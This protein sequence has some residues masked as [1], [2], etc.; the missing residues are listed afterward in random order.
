MSR[1]LILGLFIAAVA[2]AGFAQSTYYLNCGSGRDAA[3]GL[4]PESAWD[5]IERAN[6]VLFQPGDRLVLRRGSTCDGMLAPK[7]SGEADAPIV[8]SAYGEGALPVIR[9]GSHTAGLELSNQEYWEIEDLEIM[10]GSPY[11]LHITTGNASIRHFRLRNLV[12]HHVIGEPKMKESGLLVVSPAQDAAGTISDVLI[13]GVTAYDTTQWAGILVTGAAF[14][15]KNHKYGEQIEIRNSVVHDI[16]GDG[17]LLMSVRKGQ[18]EHNVAWN[19]GMQETET[20][21][22]PNAIWEWMCV[23]CRVA[24][25]EGFFSDSPG[26]DGGIF[27]IDFGDIDNVVEHNFGHDSQ[28]YCA[29]VFGAEGRGGNSVNSILRENTC[30][31]NA[32]SPRLARRQGAIFVDTWH[33][34]K[35]DGVLIEGNTILWEPP[36]AAPA[37]HAAAEFTGSR[38]NRIED[39]RILLASGDAIQVS[40]AFTVGANQVCAATS[41][42]AA[43]SLCRCWS[44]WTASLHALAAPKAD[45]IHLADGAGSGWRLVAAF[46]ATPAGS[47][48][49]ALVVLLESMRYQFSPLGL[50]TLI[51]PSGNPSE[52][53]MDRL[54]TDWHL[55]PSILVVPNVA[56]ASSAGQE[57]PPAILLMNPD[58]VVTAKWRAP[59]DPAALWLELEAHLGVPIGMQPSPVCQK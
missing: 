13:D 39:N 14:N 31:H 52:Q 8:L 56:K 34:G 21:G 28:G 6:A 45:N 43:H 38:A 17:I 36:L 55:D 29:A 15:D 50:Q 9:G 53:D 47:D 32:R 25:N 37:I 5:S 7:G 24:W 59:V 57:D 11:G 33:G 42:D 40:P 30:L 51:A 20:I 27:D 1:R 19:T 44:E 58:G 2:H 54:R 10:G 49:R 3:D 4:R 22:T 48:A 41:T 12:I 35:L 16:A 18:I 26:V 23:E 46:R